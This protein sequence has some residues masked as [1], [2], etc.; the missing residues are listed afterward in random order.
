MKTRGFMGKRTVRI[1]YKLRL[2]IVKTALEIGILKT[3]EIYSVSYSSISRWLKKYR[4]FEK[5]G[6]KNRSNKMQFQ[7]ARISDELE[8]K[9]IELKTNNPDLS[10]RKISKQLKD[11]CSITTISKVIK[12]YYE[13]LDDKNTEVLN[14]PDDNTAFLQSFYFHYHK[15]TIDEKKCYI[16]VLEDVSSGICFSGISSELSDYSIGVFW[17]LLLSLFSIHK[18]DTSKINILTI[19]RLIYSQKTS[20]PVQVANNFGAKV[21]KILNKEFPKIDWENNHD[22]FNSLL[23]YSLLENMKKIDGNIRMFS[24]EEY[25]KKSI[26]FIF[27][28]SMFN[29]DRIKEEDFFKSLYEINN[30]KSRILYVINYFCTN[31]Q[32]KMDGKNLIFLKRL[33]YNDEIFE[34]NLKLKL[35]MMRNYSIFSEDENQEKR[36]SLLES[37]HEKADKYKLIGIKLMMLRDLFYFCFKIKDY[38]KSM[39]YNERL[40]QT[41]NNENCRLNYFLGMIRRGILYE[42]KYC[43]EKSLQTYMKL[44]SFKDILAEPIYVK[45]LYGN[46]GGIYLKKRNYERSLNYLKK[47]ELMITLQDVYPELELD[48]LTNLA[49]LYSN[50]HVYNKAKDIYETLLPIIINSGEIE[51]YINFL[52]AYVHFNIIFFEKEK[53]LSLL[54]LA[55]KFCDQKKDVGSLYQL[56]CYKSYFYMEICSYEA[57]LLY[58]DKAIVLYSNKEVDSSIKFYCFQLKSDI[59]FRLK[60]YRSSHLFLNKAVILNDSRVSVSVK[61]RLSWK[62][63]R[64]KLTTAVNSNSNSNR[65]AYIID[66]IK[67][68]SNKRFEKDD[69]AIMFYEIYFILKTYKYINENIKFFC[70]GIKKKCIRILEEL[71]E[72]YKSKKYIEMKEKLILSFI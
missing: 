6:L 60:K 24:D 26:F 16:Y 11:K 29:I 15:I 55:Y 21:R 50:M 72:I 18:F 47:A 28:N 35:L 12:R 39:I 53:C 4:E 9:I 69:R 17:N 37:I 38:R 67:K 52:I 23:I 13:E 1:S 63:L 10:L 41:A 44:I 59:F 48:I 27:C 19:P 58:V 56:H 61:N 49:I 8:K 66:E 57:A 36:I 14:T 45:M 2:E 46:I 30:S 54:N 68:L 51:K 43:Y 3:T 65:I 62:V 31:N 22:N 5:E 7:P 32:D 20:Y 70:E 34:G 64:H 71:I 25:V 42:K 33:I 40:I